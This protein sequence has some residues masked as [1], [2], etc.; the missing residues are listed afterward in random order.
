[1][2]DILTIGFM[3]H[4]I[5]NEYTTELLKGLI[6]AAKELDINLLILPGQALNG[7]YYDA[8]YAAY[9]YQNNVIY[10]YCCKE[11]LDGLIISAGT[12]SS[13]VSE[14]TF[15]Q[16]VDRFKDIPL[17]TLESKV[18]NYPCIRYDGSGMYGAVE[19][20]I[21]VHGLKRIGFVS[22]PKGNADADSRL[23]AYRKALSDN[24]IAADESIIAYGNF[25]EYSMDAV[26]EI[27]NSENG[28][29]EAICFAN[30]TMC[31]GGYKVLAEKG[32]VPGKDILITGYDDSETASA[33][34]PPL[35]T[36]RSSAAKLGYSAVKMLYGMIT[37]TDGFS[38]FVPESRLILRASC[39]CSCSD[40]ADISEVTDLRKYAADT[41][42]KRA[43]EVCGRQES[44]LLDD[45]CDF[46]ADIAEMC[47]DYSEETS[48]N[49][50]ERFDELLKEG[51]LNIV[52]YVNLI[53]II[54]RMEAAVKNKCRPG[55]EA[56]IQRFI[57]QIER[58]I[59]NHDLH[60]RIAYDSDFNNTIFMLNNITKDMT[61]YAEDEAE[62]FYSIFHKLGMM[63]FKSSRILFY[64]RP[65]RYRKN[66]VWEMPETLS[67]MGSQE[68]MWIEIPKK[69][70]QKLPWRDTFQSVLVPNRSR[71][72]VASII[73][74]NGMQYGVFICEAE[75]HKYKFIHSIIAQLCTSI[76]MNL[77]VRSLE[78]SLSEEKTHNALLSEISMTDELT[79]IF[80]RRGFYHYANDVLKNPANKDKHAYLIFA[81]LNNLKKIN[82]IFGH[83][84][85]DYAI[86]TTAEILTDTLPAK[87]IVSRIGGDEFAALTVASFPDCS[88][89]IFDKIK[90]A[91]KQRNILSDKPYNVTVSIGICDFLCSENICVQDYLEL[92]DSALYEDKQKKDPD[93]MKK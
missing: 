9:E 77:L 78:S 59:Y 58:Q 87:S 88:Q 62:C 22:G 1:M 32:L 2:S 7:E 54:D 74:S 3:I 17:I 15:E 30:D 81:D 37:G 34:D 11:N 92:A 70:N 53:S 65:I 55:S 85:G 24:G 18:G 80:N 50:T 84:A 44:K 31:I 40:D 63:G 8:V 86:R 14:K 48:K 39:G 46:A 93:I 41:V 71:I 29:P 5:D 38:D 49:N 28:I 76:R 4:Q 79:H 42:R 90:E 72:S 89:A 10:E 43:D 52:G 25:S 75:I 20:L 73:A 23:C 60:R 56:Q 45:I 12:L 68:E 27:L 64:D 35:T 91:A 19:H 33:L 26:N 66:S 51:C 83:E 47:T 61:L 69:N 6:P 57:R 82:D 21:K 16:F 13:F 67:L 36:V